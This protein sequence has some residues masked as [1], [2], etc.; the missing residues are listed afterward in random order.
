MKSPSSKYSDLYDFSPVGYLTLDG[1]GLILEAN[2]TFAGLVGVERGHLIE[3]PFQKYMLIEDADKFCLH[4]NNV[5]E[6]K[7]HLTCEVRLV[8]KVAVIYG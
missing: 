1:N 4:L 8:T 3:S 7:E 2:L 6:N 5:V